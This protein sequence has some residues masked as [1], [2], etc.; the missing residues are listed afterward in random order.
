MEMMSLYQDDK[1]QDRCR[2]ADGNK[3]VYCREMKESSPNSTLTPRLTPQAARP[4]RACLPAGRCPF[5]ATRPAGG[6]WN[7]A[8][9]STADSGAS[10]LPARHASP[11]PPDRRGP[12]SLQPPRRQTAQLESHRPL[13]KNTM[14]VPTEW[15]S[16]DCG[17]S[18]IRRCFF[19]GK[20]QSLIQTIQIQTP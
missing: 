9:S 7:R 5:A 13:A 20:K 12:G 19:W 8:T 10:P 6:V 1:A 3:R 2:S 15:F 14:L 17:K 16:S 4:T 18:G 11:A